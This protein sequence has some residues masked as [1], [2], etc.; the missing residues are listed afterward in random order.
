MTPSCLQSN[1]PGCNYSLLAD[2]DSV[3]KVRVTELRI[4]AT[5][6][7]IESALAHIPILLLRPDLTVGLGEKTY[8]IV[9]IFLVAAASLKMLQLPLPLPT[10]NARLARM[11]EPRLPKLARME[12][13]MPRKWCRE[14]ADVSQLLVHG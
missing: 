14:S 4:S 11:G 13:R 7:I 6:P 12:M 1:K 10:I 8:T 2:N 3:I 5:G 9:A